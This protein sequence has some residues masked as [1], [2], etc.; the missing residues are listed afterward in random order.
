MSQ[1]ILKEGEIKGMKG[2]IEK[3]KQELHAKDERIAQFQKENEV[4][5]ERI[6]K[7]KVRLRGKGLL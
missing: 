2:S 5:Q 4:L 7:L 1:V 6:N 3:L